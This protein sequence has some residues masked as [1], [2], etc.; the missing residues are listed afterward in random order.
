LRDLVLGIAAVTPRIGADGKAAAR[1]EGVLTIRRDR[2]GVARSSCGKRSGGGGQARRGR[3][4]VT[5][6][7]E[8]PGY[9]RRVCRGRSRGKSAYS[10]YNP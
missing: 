10:N 4:R 2:S 9:L 8:I 6:G 1:E 7:P 3:E 5:A